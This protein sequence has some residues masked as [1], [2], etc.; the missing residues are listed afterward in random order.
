MQNRQESV[1]PMIDWA[2]VDTVLLD[3]DGTLLDL[4]YDNY[5]WNEYLPEK[6]GLLRGMDAET[7]RAVLMPRLRAHEGKLSWYCLDYW[8]RELEIDILALK[9]DIEHLIRVRPHVHEF[10]SF[11]N[12]TGK[13][14]ILVTN[15]H[16][17]LLS[18]KL[19]RTGIGHC[20]DAVVSSHALG[21]PKEEVG[22]WDR[23]SRLHPF[24]A[25][26]TLFIDDNV[27]VLRAARAYGIRHL[28]T[29]RQPDSRAAARPPCEFQALSAFS[30]ICARERA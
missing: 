9:A 11:L 8:S 6:W 2:A 26:R 30:E 13:R 23:F 28:L 17:K 4:Y 12:E 14:S 7:A 20:F 24:D 29:I 27:A 22:F 1:K 10:L 15:S 16:E 3:M 21:L 19:E 25:E 18:I 5:F